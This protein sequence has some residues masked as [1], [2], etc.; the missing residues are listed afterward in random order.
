MNIKQGIM[1]GIIVLC[2][3]LVSYTEELYTREAVVIE[4]EDG[5]CCVEDTTGNTWEF[6][7]NELPVGCKVTLTMRDFHTSSIRDDEITKVTVKED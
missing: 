2:I 3:G 1:A 4:Y 5:V 6:E 7:G